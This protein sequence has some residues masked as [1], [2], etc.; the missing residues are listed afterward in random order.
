MSVSERMGRQTVAHRK[1]AKVLATWLVI[2][3]MV[4]FPVRKDGK[5]EWKARKRDQMVWSNHP[6]FVSPT[7]VE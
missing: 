7:N 2:S 4:M 5:E 3:L 1:K 6:R